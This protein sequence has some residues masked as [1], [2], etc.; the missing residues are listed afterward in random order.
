[1]MPKYRHVWRKQPGDDFETCSRCG[2]QKRSS[3][4]YG[5]KT[6]FVW[7]YRNGYDRMAPP[8]LGWFWVRAR[9][10]VP[11]CDPTNS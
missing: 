2:M 1:M 4:R 7:E 11:R 9:E 8:N 6:Y 5:W 3:I 10:P